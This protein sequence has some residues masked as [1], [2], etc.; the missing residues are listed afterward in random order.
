MI[1]DPVT[2]SASPYGPPNRHSPEK[3]SC[4]GRQIYESGIYY[5]K[6]F[7]VCYGYTATNSISINLSVLARPAMPIVDRMGL[8]GWSAVPK[9]LA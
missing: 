5:V 2:T 9:Y 4:L 1:L 8:V 3:T 6:I 7:D